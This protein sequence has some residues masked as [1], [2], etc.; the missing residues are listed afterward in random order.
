ML[1]GLKRNS[2]VL[3][4]FVMFLIVVLTNPARGGS[5]TVCGT[6]ITTP[7]TYVLTS[8]LSTTSGTCITITASN[9]VL[10]CQGYWISGM[11]GGSDSK[12][13]LLQGSV[14]ST[15]KNC[16]I[17]DFNGLNAT[18][19]AKGIVV[20]SGGNHTI[21][22]N[23]MLDTSI[24]F[25]LNL[26]GNGNIVMNNR[27]ERTTIGFQVRTRN[28]I[29]SNNTMIGDPQSS[30]SRGFS[31]FTSGTGNLFQKNVV[32]NNYIGF[33]FVPSA[34]NVAM[35]NVYKNNMVINNSYGFFIP[36]SHGG[37]TIHSNIIRNNQQGIIVTLGQPPGLRMG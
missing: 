2:V 26:N 9:V 25:L 24:G 6:T 11:G 18:D 21:S 5:G 30:S 32:L 1:L 27:A 20:E 31:I 12:G 10:D 28:N 15:I 4:V 14:G 36:S 29:I 23:L 13:I 7:G 33:Y 37:N 8:N 16:N 22:N 34:P 35:N 19:V 3:L 17:K